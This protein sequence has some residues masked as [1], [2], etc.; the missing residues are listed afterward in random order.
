MDIVPSENY[1]VQYDGEEYAVT[2]G[3]GA[4]LCLT[5]HPLRLAEEDTRAVKVVQV[6]D[7][8]TEETK[9]SVILPDM[10]DSEKELWGIALRVAVIFMSQIM[11]E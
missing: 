8:E 9:H 11:G 10:A 7:T 3:D 2:I 6:T 1:T 4:P 5:V